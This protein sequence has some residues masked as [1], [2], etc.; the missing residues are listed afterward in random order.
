MGASDIRENSANAVS[1][2][3]NANH[4]EPEKKAVSVDFNALPPGGRTCADVE[5]GL[6]P[7]A[8]GDDDNVYHHL[9]SYYLRKTSF[10]L[11]KRI[12]ER[13]F[14]EY[15]LHIYPRE[16]RV[17]FV[18]LDSPTM[19]TFW[20]L[21]PNIFTHV[22]KMLHEDRQRYCTCP[23]L[24]VAAGQDLNRMTC[25]VRTSLDSGYRVMCRAEISKYT[26]S[27]SRFSV[28]L[29]DYGFYKWV[30][31]TDVYDIS[32]VSKVWHS[33]QFWKPQTSWYGKYGK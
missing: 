18:R 7:A 13:A 27:T 17:R 23:Q 32:S 9:M 14:K 5:A 21:D 10:L 29:V 19:D 28:Y 1:G 4:W 22:E 2:G 30:K 16:M 31:D 24:R 12:K 26:G 11:L 3:G 6:V 15:E 25:M 33:I 8:T 20:V